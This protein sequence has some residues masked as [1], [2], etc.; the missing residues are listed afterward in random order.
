MPALAEFQTEFARALLISDSALR[1]QLGVGLA[2]YQNTVMKGLVDVLRANYPT[3]EQLVGTEWFESAALLCAR[4][5]L[6]EQPALAMYGASFAAFIDAPAAAQGL[7]YLSSVAR[8]DRAWTEAHFA[9]DA[10][11]LRAASLQAI[12]PGQLPNITLRWHPATRVLWVPHSAVSIWQHNRPPAQPPEGF[13]LDDVEQGLLVTRPDG[14][15]GVRQIHRAD[16][17]FLQ[18]L[19]S[20]RSLGEAA[21]AVLEQHPDTDVASVL[22]H[23]I[24]AGAFAS[25]AN[26][27]SHL[28]V[29][30]T[31]EKTT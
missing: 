5:H 24:Q 28:S 29:T 30:P 1:H 27:E 22:A 10:K 15:I 3:V 20:G 19:H 26:T 11:V 12:A 17:E 8:L 21:I 13:V 9:A 23:L 4:E 14:A 18:H 2:V 7:H 16:Y 6:P 25:L 31:Q